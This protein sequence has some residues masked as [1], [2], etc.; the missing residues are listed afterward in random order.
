MEIQQT[1]P[2]SP[3]QNGVA[4][5]MNRTLVELAHMMITALKLPEFLWEPTVA[6]VA[7]V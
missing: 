6:H 7:Y 5:R 3:S 1:A 2:Y 4:E